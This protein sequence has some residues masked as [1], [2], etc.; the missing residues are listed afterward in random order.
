MFRSNVQNFVRTLPEM[1]HHKEKI[2]DIFIHHLRIKDS[3]AFQP[4]LE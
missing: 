4:L 1:L 2:C 3:L